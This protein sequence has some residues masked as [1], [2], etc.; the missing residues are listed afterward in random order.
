MEAPAGS[1]HSGLTHRRAPARAFPPDKD[2]CAGP[3]RRAN[4]EDGTL[5][6]RA[7]PQAQNIAAPCFERRRRIAAGFDEFAAHGQHWRVADCGD[8]ERGAGV[9]AD[10]LGAETLGYLQHLSC[11]SWPRL[12]ARTFIGV[13]ARCEADDPTG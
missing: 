13:G 6:D 1:R 5:A 8:A 11:P 9:I 12:D 7:D 4:L 3:A 10:N 2:G